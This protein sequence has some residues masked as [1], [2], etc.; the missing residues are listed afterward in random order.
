LP[1][2][3]EIRV[4]L[5]TNLKKE[6][7]MKIRLTNPAN[8]LAMLIMVAA[9]AF[10]FSCSSD[11]GDSKSG[12]SSSSDETNAGIDNSSSSGNKGSSSS[13]TGNSSSSSGGGSSSSFVLELC[14]HNGQDAY[15]QWDS[16]CAN[17]TNAA[18]TCASEIDN[19]KQYGQLYVGVSLPDDALHLPDGIT[20]LAKGEK[21]ENYGGTFIEGAEFCTANNKQLYCQWDTGCFVISANEALGSDPCESEI[22]N[23]RRWGKPFINVDPLAVGKG[24]ECESNGGNEFHCCRGVGVGSSFYYYWSIEVNCGSDTSVDH[25]YCP[26]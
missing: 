15:C 19:C 5:P 4:Y 8:L 3:G 24:V 18:G 9:M 25:S 1:F 16:G 26:Q 6:L 11:D 17:V 21:C 2:F 14:K 23:C 7:F 13:G 10:T 12:D 20:L 22:D